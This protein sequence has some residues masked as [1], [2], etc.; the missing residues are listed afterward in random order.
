MGSDTVVDDAAHTVTEDGTRIIVE[1]NV[2]MTT[3]DGVVLRADIYRPASEGKYPVLLCRTPYSKDK[4]FTL[5]PG[6][7]ISA[8][9]SPTEGVANGYVYVVQDCRGSGASD[10]GPGNYRMYADEKQDGADAVEWASKL[11]YC[12]G[13]VAIFGTSYVGAAAYQAATQTPDGLRA[14][15]INAGP[16]DFYE[17]HLHYGGALKLYLTGIWSISR[18]AEIAGRRGAGPD[19]MAEL[20]A[21]VARTDEILRQVP[22][23][24]IP[25]FRPEDPDFAPFYFDILKHTERDDW[26][27]AAMDKEDHR[28]VEVPALVVSGWYYAITRGAIDHFVN[29][30]KSGAT[31]EARERSRLIVGP[32]TVRAVGGRAGGG[33]DYGQAAAASSLFGNDSLSAVHLRFFD[34]LLKG[35][36]IEDEPRVRLFVM[37]RNEWRSEDE[38]PLSRAKDVAW[39]LGS[40]GSLSRSAAGDDEQP[41]AFAYDPNDPFPSH[42]G[43]WVAPATAEVGPVDQGPVLSRSDLLVYTSEP[44]EE[45]LEVI[46]LPKLVL[47][48]A[49]SGRDTDWVVKLCDVHPDGTTYNVTDGILRA[50]YRNS[51]NKPE[52]LEPGEVARY[53]VELYPTAMAFLAGHRLRIMITSGDYPRYDRN[54]NTGETP[55]D[56]TMFEVAN[57]QVFHDSTRPSHI[58]LPTIDETK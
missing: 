44:L 33:L 36:S 43:A 26:T 8:A 35:K 45:D 39:H 20:A 49:T 37:G 16:N 7:A 28:K 56:A 40:S 55:A 30:R 50:R 12:N 6:P 34:R 5:D 57:Q 17:D 11:E 31:E 23:S 15:G 22:L 13:K 48:A 1:K 3:R 47:Y 58:I 25:E 42:G 19:E 10:S 29:L 32:W 27:R 38:Y 53:E 52:L 21:N 46:G 18:A 4:T 2:E 24:G 54:P 14:I 9:I 51:P 41:D